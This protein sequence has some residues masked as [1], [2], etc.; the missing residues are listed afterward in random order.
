VN[1]SKLKKK[2][3]KLFQGHL[4]FDEF[5]FYCLKMYLVM[6]QHFH[7]QASVYSKYH[8]SLLDFTFVVPSLFSCWNSR[9]KENPTQVQSWLTLFLNHT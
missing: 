5:L 3:E 8:F 6:K 7:F 1:I 2:G 9:W 4:T